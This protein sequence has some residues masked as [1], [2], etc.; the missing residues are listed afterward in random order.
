MGCGI[1]G[2]L[3]PIWRNSCQ[4][5]LI[6]KL[7]LTDFEIWWEISYC[8]K[9]QL[10]EW[11][12]IYFFDFIFGPVCSWSFGLESF[13]QCWA[14]WW[15]SF[16]RKE[17]WNSAIA[18]G[19]DGNSFTFSEDCPEADSQYLRMHDRRWGQKDQ[20]WGTPFIKQVFGL[21]LER[22]NGIRMLCNLWHFSPSN[23]N[24]QIECSSLVLSLPSH[25]CG[26]IDYS[27]LLTTAF[28]SHLH[29]KSVPKIPR[30][31][32]CWFRSTVSTSFITSFRPN[33]WSDLSDN[34]GSCS[35]FPVRPLGIPIRP[36]VSESVP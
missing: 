36:S 23:C 8:G 2:G 9:G 16:Q 27:W 32:E 5:V 34:N 15:G 7:H 12:I 24:Y 30:M 10:H 26:S 29:W 33:S 14:G 22:L 17:I 3:S 21:T 13:V 4:S 1:C 18:S 11:S 6:P 20:V 31:V 19:G 35:G 25:L 28:P